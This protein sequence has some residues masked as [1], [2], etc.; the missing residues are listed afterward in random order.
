MN[1]QLDRVRRSLTFS[2]DELTDLGLAWGVLAVAFALFLG[3]PAQ[4][5]AAP[6]TALSL[7]L[8]S[9]ITVGAGFLLHEIAHKVVAVRFGQRASFKANYRMLVVAV[10]S[11]LAGLII[12]APGAVHHRGRVTRRQRGVI[13]V[14]GPVTN[15]VLV[16]VFA[17]L[18]LVGGFIGD[19]GRFGV[20]INAFL[21]A[22]NMLPF[23]PLDGKTVWSW[24]RGI[25]ALV[26]LA[27]AVTTITSAVLLGFVA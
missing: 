10:L 12:A 5:V 20:V 14:A 26:F 19:I 1:V 23:G 7:L 21:A 22:F 27:G 3:Q 11:A 24:H 16:V 4:F 2:R 8:L 17:P 6:G 25:F 18:V 9:A 15:L 13:A